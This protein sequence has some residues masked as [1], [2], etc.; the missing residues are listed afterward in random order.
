MIKNMKIF[1]IIV[2]CIFGLVVVGV[3]GRAI[4]IAFLP[5][6]VI[7]K[8]IQTGEQIID[9]TLTGQNAIYNYEWFKQQAED[10]KAI[11]NK[12]TIAQNAEVSFTNVAGVRSTWTFEDKTESSRLAA[13]KQGLQSQYQDM[14]ATYN[15]RSKMANRN[16]FESGLIPNVLTMGSNFLK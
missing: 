2:A 15:A 5:V 6:R 11:E 12:I 14:I 13:I 7:D 1:G 8:T 4:R 16:I 10:I 3:V 9:K